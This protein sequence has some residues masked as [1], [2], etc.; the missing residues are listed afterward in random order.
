MT[1]HKTIEVKSTGKTVIE[2]TAIK[3][4]MVVRVHQKIKDVNAKGE[5]RERIQVFEGLV[6]ARNHGSQAGATFR[7]RKVSE[8]VGVEKI[9]P[10]FSP[11]IDKIELVDEKVVRRAKLYFAPTYTKRLKSRAEKAQY[12]KLV[13]KRASTKKK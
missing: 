3:A 13:A 6:M 11:L 5:E 7:V 4:G 12:Q 1:E 10:L 9:F 8:G 2:R